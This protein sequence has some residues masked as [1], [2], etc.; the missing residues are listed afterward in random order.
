MVL[1]FLSIFI[2]PIQFT[3]T[4]RNFVCWL[5]LFLKSNSWKQ[6]LATEGNPGENGDQAPIVTRQQLPVKPY[7]IKL[8]QHPLQ[9]SI[10]QLSG[11]TPDNQIPNY[12]EPNVSTTRHKLQTTNPN[13]G[14]PVQETCSQTTLLKIIGQ[15]H[16]TTGYQTPGKQE[17]TSGNRQSY[18][19]S[20]THSSTCSQVECMINGCD[21]KLSIG[22]IS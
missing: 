9:T 16:Q 4:N 11:I 20:L 7:Q 12:S 17:P 22:Q 19:S 13:I 3:T 1:S 2:Y 5:H 10:Y 6:V 14:E 18:V 15:Q 21:C 8:T